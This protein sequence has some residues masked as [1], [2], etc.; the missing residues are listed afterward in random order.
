MRGEIITNPGMVRQMS[1]ILL[2]TGIP[3]DKNGMGE[4]LPL[5]LYLP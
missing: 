4:I 2:E 1:R 3:D 5:K